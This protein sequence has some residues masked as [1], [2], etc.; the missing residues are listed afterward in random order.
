VTA[1]AKAPLPAL[2][3]FATLAALGLGALVCWAA[4]AEVGM[5]LMATSQ[6]DQERPTL[7]ANPMTPFMPDPETAAAAQKAMAD[8]QVSAL[9]SMRGARLLVLM[10][11]STASA[12]VF[13]QALRLNWPSGMPRSGLARMLGASAIGV[14]ILRTMDGAQQLAVARRAGAAF[15]KVMATTRVEAAHMPE[16]LG[17]MSL[18]V[19]TVGVTLVMTATFV[20]LGLY[21]RSPKVAEVL[22]G[23]DEQLPDGDER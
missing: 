23:A 2:L 6:E 13:V 20:F 10:L 16:G 9:E 15:D 1:K 14:G 17:T 4:S 21:F 7:A 12:L 19:F 22:A 11:L 5:T 8:A 3:R 18:S